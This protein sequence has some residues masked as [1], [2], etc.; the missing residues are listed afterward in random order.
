M[1][2][3]LGNNQQTH[4]HCQCVVKYLAYLNSSSV[5]LL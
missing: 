2:N 3:I 5:A 4:G 1:S